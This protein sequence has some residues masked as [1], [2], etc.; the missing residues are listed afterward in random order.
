MVLEKH[1]I[2]MR[3]STDPAKYIAFHKVIDIRP[4]SINDIMVV[5]NI[6]LDHDDQLLI[7]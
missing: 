6:H 1:V 4:E 3:T 2:F 7:V 5:P